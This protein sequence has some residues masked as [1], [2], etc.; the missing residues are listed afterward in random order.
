MSQLVMKGESEDVAG[1]FAQTRGEILVVEV[2]DAAEV[3]LRD[4]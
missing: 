4:Q 2:G 3:A 1:H